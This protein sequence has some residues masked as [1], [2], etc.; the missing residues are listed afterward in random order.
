[1]ASGRW[2]PL[3]RECREPLVSRPTAETKA[4]DPT[5]VYALNKLDQETLCLI[6][7]R[8]YA[9]PTVALRFFNVY[10]PRQS[11][12][13][14]YTGVAAIFSSRI[15]AGN[16]PLIYEDG[17]QLRDFVSVRDVVAACRLVMDN[18]GA[19]GRALNVGSGSAVSVSEIA[20]IL[21]EL[22]GAAGRIE[23]EISGR[24]RTG[25]IRHCYAD[26]SALR[27]L[28]YEPKVQLEDGMRE[29]VEWAA[30]AVASDRFDAARQELELKGLA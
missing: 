1:M 25:D 27:Q 4:L 16:P 5:S 29:L 9:I 20:A 2:E 10:G 26:I 18:D 21:L 12:S 7:G 30:G 22:H 24:F 15:K 13:N 3:C 11:L 8:A 14:P 23:P 6:V 28:G 19:S 17:R